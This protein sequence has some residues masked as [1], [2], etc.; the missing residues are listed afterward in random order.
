MDK[1]ENEMDL[2]RTE[3]LLRIRKI[4]IVLRVVSYTIFLIILISY[5]IAT[6]LKLY[7]T[8]FVLII[9]V[10]L[11]CFTTAM[12]MGEELPSKA[13]IKGE[14]LMFLVMIF[15]AIIIVWWFIDKVYN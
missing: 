4:N 12:L 14:L 13:S 11:S 3:L 1:K 7:N 2:T 6:Y 8:S 9:L 10:C 15:I 5:L